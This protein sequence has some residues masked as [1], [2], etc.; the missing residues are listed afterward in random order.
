MN[1]NRKRDDESPTRSSNMEPAEGSRETLQDTTNDLGSSSDRA[2]FDE[3][4]SGERSSGDT[5]RRERVKGSSSER[6]RSKSD[7]VMPDDDATLK[8][9]I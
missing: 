8:T 4:L 2:M 1:Q 6:G 7:P 5:S 3:R 9:K